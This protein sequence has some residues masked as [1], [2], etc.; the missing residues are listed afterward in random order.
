[1]QIMEPSKPTDIAESQVQNNERTSKDKS[2]KPKLSKTLAVDSTISIKGLKPYWDAQCEVNSSKLWLPI[3]TDLH[4]LDLN[5][6]NGLSNKVVEGSWFSSKLIYPQSKN[7]QTTYSAFFT[8][9]VAECTDSEIIKSKSNKLCQTRTQKWNDCRIDIYNQTI[10]YIRSC[11]KFSPSWMEIKKDLLKQL[12][13]W[14]NCNDVP[15]QIK[16]IAVKRSTSGI[17]ES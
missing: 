6:L 8:S 5:S 9:S 10:D 2:Q 11:V 14:C 1:M 15:F 17:L 3:K 13:K 7:L 12:P 4:G 16:A